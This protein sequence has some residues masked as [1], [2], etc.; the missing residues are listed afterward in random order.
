MQ[1]AVSRPMP[2]RTQRLS[3]VPSPR[4]RFLPRPPNQLRTEPRATV[5]G[6]KDDAAPHRAAI[7]ALWRSHCQTGIGPQGP[8][9]Y[10]QNQLFLHGSGPVRRAAAT[11]LGR[12]RVHA[13]TAAATVEGLQLA[14]GWRA[15]PFVRVMNLPLFTCLPARSASAL[16]R[17]GSAKAD[18][19]ALR[20]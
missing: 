20:P 16:G 17:Q 13:Q 18:D 8:I 14:P 9:P 15:V 11:L 6:G 7:L 10:Y 2:G 5:D 3:T 12:D 4:A 19:A 1:T